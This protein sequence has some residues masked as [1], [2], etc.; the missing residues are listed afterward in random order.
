MTPYEASELLPKFRGF[1]P[2][3]SSLDRL[4]KRLSERWEQNRWDW[5]DILRQQE[6]VPTEAAIVGLSLDGIKLPMKDGQR[7]EKRARA[8]EK[9]KKPR[10]PNGYREVG[11]GTVTA[12]DREGE[13]L[14]TSYYGRMPESMKPTLQEQLEA[15]VSSI[16]QAAPAGLRLV[17]LSDGAPDNW[18]ILREIVASLR[19]QGILRA[20]VEVYETNDFFHS[21]E[22]LKV[23]TDLYYG[24]NSV[25]S[26]TVFTELRTLLLEADDGVERVIRKLTYF[27]NRTRVKA[28]RRALTKKLRYF[29]F[30]KDQMRYAESRN[31]NLPIGSGVVE[32]AC[33]TL[34][35]Q[36]MKRSGMRWAQEGGQAVLT[37][38][39]LLRSKRWD[40]GWKLLAGSYRPEIRVITRKL[41]LEGVHILGR[42]A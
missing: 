16:L 31:S 40:G 8:V 27:R 15:E 17:L 6:T 5:E 41:H 32:A 22:H 2:S 3:R 4:P 25:K 10:G 13:R 9:G 26:R 29:R 39:S 37:L 11:C 12:Y 35:T 33:K 20:D 34:V 42:A 28:R 14:E 21:A 7:E 36:R 24:E 18:R 30:R 19:E 38:R 23:A 1:E